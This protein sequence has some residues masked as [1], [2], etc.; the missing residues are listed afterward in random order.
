[1]QGLGGTAPGLNRGAT[2]SGGKAGGAVDPSPIKLLR[3]GVRGG[4]ASPAAINFTAP[5]AGRYMFVAW[6][7]GGLGAGGDGAGA[8]ALAI[9]T[10]RLSLSQVIPMTLSSDAGSTSS[11]STTVTFPDGVMTAGTGQN[12]SAGGAGGVASGGDINVNGGVA[13]GASGGTAGSFGEFIGGSS[14]QTPGG[15]GSATPANGGP[16]VLIVIYVGE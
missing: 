13:S 10:V 12:Q 5:K 7:G 8:G 6:G 2:M 1:M 4:G 3:F 9:R 16:G 11:P 14:L 15:G